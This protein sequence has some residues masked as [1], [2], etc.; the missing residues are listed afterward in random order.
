MASTISTLLGRGLIEE[1]I[2]RENTYIL[3]GVDQSG[4]TNTFQINNSDYYFTSIFSGPSELWV[5]DASTIRLQ[6]ISLSYSLPEKLLNS[7]PFGSVSLTAIGNNLWY[8][9]INT[10]D[11]ANFDPNTSGLGVGNGFGFDYINGPSSRRYG[12]SIKLTF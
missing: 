9:A 4:N 8:N 3:P 5:Y 1:T 6:E 11:G 2:D 7:T 12:F 10:P